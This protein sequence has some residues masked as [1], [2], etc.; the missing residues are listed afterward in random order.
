MTSCERVLAAVG[1]RQPDRPPLEYLATAAVS[2]R[3]RE[4]AGCADDEALRTRLG[5]DFRRLTLAVRKV[6]PLPAAAERHRD[7]GTE[8]RVDGYGTVVLSSASFPQGHRVYG[9]FYESEDLDSFDWPRPAD[10]EEVGPHA[11]ALD[12]WH[13][14]GLCSVVRG[15]NPFKIAGFMRG[16][17]QLL[18][19]CLERPGFVR[20]LLERIG[21]VES[22]RWQAGVRAG[23]R[24]AMVF[25]DFADQRSLMISP[26][27][28]RELL[29][30]VLA[31][32][33]GAVRAIRPEVLAFL[34]SDG[35]LTEVLADLVE[36]GFDAVH[37][38]QP[39]CM[40]LA[41]VK[42]RYA[43]RLTIFGGLSV[44]SELPNTRPEEV[45][46]LVRARIQALGR[47]GGLI[48]A[49]T[50]SMLPDISDECI[51]ALYEEAR[52]GEAA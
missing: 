38:L 1:H 2:A 10:V 47:G 26:L 30:P 19:D 35:N 51:L 31:G 33:V 14:R 49:P 52:R 15:D 45:R 6:H 17:D 16:F 22:A 46:A 12:G 28:F 11:P 50:N 40:D 20:A 9:P 7:P 24:A 13:E 39:E 5:V 23:A 43:G 27:L 44:Q 21:Q 29:A 34:H 32:M 42:R 4:S 25:G 48:L 3:L 36:C 18:V 37:P 8:L 41:E